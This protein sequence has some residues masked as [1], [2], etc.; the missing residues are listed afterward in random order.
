MSFHIRKNIFLLIFFFMWGIGFYYGIQAGD[1][2]GQISGIVSEQNGYS[3]SEL[4]RYQDDRAILS[5]YQVKKQSRLEVPITGRTMACDLLLTWGDKMIICN[6]PLK[7]GSYGIGVR[8]EC[9]ISLEIARKLFKSD[10]PTGLTLLWDGRSWLIKGVMDTLEP[11]ALFTAD[12]N[13]VMNH[14]EFLFYKK[15]Q[16]QEQAEAILYEGQL[17]KEVEMMDYSLF[18]AVSR[19]FYIFPSIILLWKI[20]LKVSSRLKNPWMG[21]LLWSAFWL[22]FALILS[23][24]FRFPSYFLP[25]KW[26]DFDFWSARWNDI[27][28]SLKKLFRSEPLYKQLLVRR[29]TGFSILCST[30]ASLGFI[31]LNMFSGLSKSDEI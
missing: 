26:S 21:Y 3:I 28:N 27:I 1:A 7:Y 24:M 19:F 30:S 15:C 2:D 4:N 8:G 11:M 29:Q 20:R 12:E 9:V 25:S 13:S 16:Y 5:A 14:L 10:N 18:L 22:L 6:I 31:F 23:Q 17:D